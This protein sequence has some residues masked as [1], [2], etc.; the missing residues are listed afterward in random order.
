MAAGVSARRLRHPTL[1]SPFHGARSLPAAPIPL[2]VDA[3]T[4]A[5]ARQADIA[6]RA[7]AY[8]TVAPPHVFFFGVTA[9]VLQAIPLPLRVLRGPDSAAPRPI[10]AAVLAPDRAPRA[11]GVRGRQFS[12]A[13]TRLASVDG[14]RVAAPATIWA[15]LAGELSLDELIVV[16]DALIHE[17]RLEGGI[18]GPAGS[19]M[20]TRADLE[21]AAA[22][23]RVGATKL[24]EALRHARV[25]AA[26][27]Q[28]TRLR[29]AIQRAGLPEPEL[30]V[31]VYDRTGFRIGYTEFAFPQ[32]RV[33][34]EY[35][36]DHHRVDK[37][38]WNRDIEKHAACV[39]AG[40][41]VV[42]LTSAHMRSDAA[43]AISRIRNALI[44]GGWTPDA[45]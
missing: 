25:G 19:G 35:E 1:E 24:R 43:P 21:E 3:A 18:R 15:Q 11:A 8:A 40:W 6:C 36:G 33:L 22:A 7:H 13:V 27:P 9:A 20:A 16:A 2:A 44:R 12:P 34:G 38:Q 28:E 32:W 29:L 39:A 4:E 14:L 30:D 10:D 17:P 23:R 5:R 31:D 41:D 45:G 37:D 26:S 42:R